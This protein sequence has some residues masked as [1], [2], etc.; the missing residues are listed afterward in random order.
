[1][2]IHTYINTHEHTYTRTHIHTY[3]RTR[4]HTYTHTHIHK[5]ALIFRCV[6]TCAYI[7]TYVCM[8]SCARKE[9]ENDRKEECCVHMYDR[10]ENCCVCGQPPPPL[11]CSSSLSHNHGMQIDGNGGGQIL[12]VEFCEWAISKNLLEHVHDTD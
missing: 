3:A 2:H 7:L 9:N 8:C 1:M 10:K 5:H 6:Y 12:F 4:I 11:S